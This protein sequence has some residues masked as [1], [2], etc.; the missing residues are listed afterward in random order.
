MIHGNLRVA[1][2]V[3]TLWVLMR[4]TYSAHMRP[5]PAYGAGANSTARAIRLPVNSVMCAIGM[6]R[7][8]IAFIIVLGHR[9]NV[10]VIHRPAPPRQ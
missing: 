4:H 7:V 5:R 10:C 9:R 3:R 6:A 8:V 1:F 2:I